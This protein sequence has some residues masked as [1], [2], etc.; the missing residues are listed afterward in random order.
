[1]IEPVAGDIRMDA[2]AELAELIRQHKEAL[3]QAKRYKEQADS[4]GDLI[5]GITGS[6]TLV[7]LDNRP[8]LSYRPIRRFAGA[9]FTREQPELAKFY[10]F[11]VTK[12]ELD[13]ELIKRTK[14]DLY[15]Q[16]QVRQLVNGWEE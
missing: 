2:N 7:Y 10:M 5:S 8:V 4:I 13:V 1:M 12:E 15:T 16:Y 11:P 3:A 6:S 14:P 9:K